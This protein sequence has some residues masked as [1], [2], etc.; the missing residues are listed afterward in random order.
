V[1]TQIYHKPLLREAQDTRE[2]LSNE[3]RNFG[4]LCGLRAH[5]EYRQH[6]Y[7]HSCRAYL[8]GLNL[9]WEREQFMA[10]LSLLG[11]TSTDEFMEYHFEHC[12][13]GGY[14][15]HCRECLAATP[16]AYLFPQSTSEYGPRRL[17]PVQR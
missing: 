5:K 13:W 2:W 1:N 11:I 3:A 10:S 4:F 8:S 16:V 9:L 17:G 15:Q 6:G 12:F 14:L 7:A